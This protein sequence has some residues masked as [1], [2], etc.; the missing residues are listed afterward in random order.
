MDYEK[1]ECPY[2]TGLLLIAHKV[3][4]WAIEQDDRLH[5]NIYT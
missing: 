3:L 4:E 5:F 2:D 1:T